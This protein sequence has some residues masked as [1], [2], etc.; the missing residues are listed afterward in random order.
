MI[1]KLAIVAAGGAI[2]SGLRFLVGHWSLK[3]LGPGFP[4]GTM[5]VNVIGSF[6]MGVIAIVL[7]ERVPGGFAKWSP[8]IM[9]GILGG[10]TTFSAF[11]LDALLLIEKGK[12]GLALGYIAASVCLSIGALWAGFTL[13]RA[14]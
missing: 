10:F 8:F 1:G 11:S 13:T 14:L 4:W 12:A 5:A 9:T 7:L 6:A 2:G 3:L